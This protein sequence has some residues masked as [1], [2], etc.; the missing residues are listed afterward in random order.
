M[1]SRRELMGI[2][3][4]YRVDK[5]SVTDSSGD[6]VDEDH[7]GWDDDLTFTATRWQLYEGSLVGAPADVA[8]AI[9]NVGDSHNELDDKGRLR[10]SRPGNVRRL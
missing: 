10:K 5:W 2:S 6:L 3:A 1:V 9:R 7:A 8:S 4:G